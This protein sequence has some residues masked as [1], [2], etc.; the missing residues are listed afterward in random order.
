MDYSQLLQIGREQLL[1]FKEIRKKFEGTTSLSCTCSGIYDQNGKECVWSI[2]QRE[3]FKP[4]DTSG[5]SWCRF[6]IMTSRDLEYDTGMEPFMVGEYFDQIFKLN[7]YV[8]STASTNYPGAG[9]TQMFIFFYAPKSLCQRIL[10]YFTSNEHECLIEDDFKN[11]VPNGLE[12]NHLF[13]GDDP[14]VNMT[15]EDKIKERRTL[16]LDLLSFLRGSEYP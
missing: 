10:E 5:C 4:E 3:N 11:F 13:E 8:Y 6:A 16:Y 1:K 2:G 15:I 12:I 7:D 9:L 14:L